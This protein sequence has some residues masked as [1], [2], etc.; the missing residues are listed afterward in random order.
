MKKTKM[1]SSAVLACVLSFGAMTPVMAQGEINVGTVTSVDRPTATPIPGTSGS[2]G[3]QSSEYDSS[4]ETTD[5]FSQIA[6]SQDVIQSGNTAGFM[7]ENASLADTGNKIVGKTYEIADWIRKFG[8]AIS[9]VTFVISAIMAAVGS[10]TRK[11]GATTAFVGMGVS[12]IVFTVCF[13]APQILLTFMNWLA[14]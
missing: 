2:S 13:Y 5:A 11:G 3:S 10:L 4:K 9:V 7:D 8:V 6:N 12:A 1:I 14:K